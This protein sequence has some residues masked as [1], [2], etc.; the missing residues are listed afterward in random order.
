MSEEMY[1]RRCSRDVCN[2]VC[3]NQNKEIR[4]KSYISYD[5]ENDIRLITSE[6]IQP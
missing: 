5:D 1:Q 2:D 6:Q 4:I 3:N